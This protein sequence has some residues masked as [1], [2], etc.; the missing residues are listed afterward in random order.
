MSVYVPFDDQRKQD[1]SFTIKS[2]GI[3][4]GIN[5]GTAIVVMIGFSLL[6]PRNSLVYA[7]KAKF[8]TDKNRPPSIAPTGWL[9]WIKPVFRVKDEI[10]LQQIGC[11]AVLYIRFVRLLRKLLLC[12]SVIGLGALIP[13]YIIATKE[14]GDWPPAAGSIEILSISGINSQN[15]KLVETPNTVWYWA[16]FSATWGFSILIA[17]F[18][19]RASCDY[20][21]MRQY[22]FR[23]PS[24]EATMKSLMVS[25]IPKS[26]QTDQDLK[27]WIESTR[28]IQHPI[29]DSMMGHHSNKLSE[30]YENHE[31]AVHQLET[32]LASYLSDGKNTDSKK[33]PTVRVG[34]MFFGLFGGKK[35]DAIE[36][37][38][39]QVAELDGEIKKLRKDQTKTAPYGWISFDKI[40]YAHQTERSLE[41]W[42]KKTDNEDVFQV[43]LSPTPTNLIWNNLPMNEKARKSKRWIGRI[44]YWVFVFVWM[45][46]MT[47]LSAT[48]NVINL[49]RLIPNSASFIESHQVLMGLIQAY[50]TPIVMAIF[51]YLLPIFFRFLSK[52]QGYWTQT[53]LDRKVLTKLYVFF[54]INNLLVFT[55]TSM[56]IGIYGQ[57]R[58]LIESGSLPSD[59]SISG[60][61]MQ[62]ARN[63][64][65]VSTFW[66]NFVC[67]KSLGLTMDLA[68]L[69]PLITITVKK[70]LTRPSPRE[71]REMAKPPE[72]NFPQNY[73]LL[74]FFFTIA[75]VY[76]A[77]SPLILPFALIYFTVAGM[78]YK[79]MLMYVYVTKI[80]SGG[81]IWPVLFQTIMTSVIFFQVTMIIMLVLKGGNLQAYILI[82]LP[83]MTLAFQYFYYRRMHTL[84][85]YLIGSDSN[86]PSNYI[87]ES[88]LGDDHHASGKKKPAA[89]K[90][91]LRDQFQDPAYHD[92]LSTPTVHEDVKHLLQK[93][94]RNSTPPAATSHGNSQ[95]R[96]KVNETIEMVQNY[97]KNM[98]HDMDL[99]QQKGFSHKHHIYDAGCPIQFETVTE[100]D[101]LEAE[102][103]D[104]EEEVTQ[105]Q[106]EMAHYA[107]DDEEDMSL[108][109]SST[110]ASSHYAASSYYNNNSDTTPLLQQQPSAPPP[111][112]THT[113]SE[114]FLTAPQT[115]MPSTNNRNITSEYIEMYSSFTPNAS[116]V[117]IANRSDLRAVS[118]EEF[119]TNDPVEPP[120]AIDRKRHTMPYSTEHEDTDRHLS[121][122]NMYHPSL[123][124]MDYLS[125]EDEDDEDIE[126]AVSGKA[127][128]LKRQLSAPVVRRRHENINTDLKRHNTV[129][130]K[131]RQVIN[132][133]GDEYTES[134]VEYEE[135]ILVED[136][137]EQEIERPVNYHRIVTEESFVDN[138][139]HPTNQRNNNV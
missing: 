2:M 64:S 32:A 135:K 131:S 11:D 89:S 55:L 105:G 20:I 7:P 115:R 126:H 129:P 91:S 36:H 50:F 37:Y 88:F 138:K 61:V 139:R 108:T 28:A 128:E 109:K 35:V 106:R 51:F 13:V 136:E 10:L 60:Y 90:S 133:F 70:F 54:I 43:R 75:L 103:E 124:S 40:E 34:G 39:K 9:S 26:K 46:P 116:G 23:L 79:Y 45:I 1:A 15:G 118:L 72:F 18:M 56:L 92:K 73:N 111:L 100:E 122:P 41:K 17:Y 69:V 66:I 3:Q 98:A 68:M 99:D 83:F 94:Y 137:D 8:S 101:I 82:P 62:I 119:G 110:F 22:Y 132:P 52:Q 48:S 67:L 25:H 76:S 49:I 16:P 59:T 6:R 74:L 78:V 47:A 87:D 77:M 21:D 84:G 53:T 81:K 5:L 104:D 86:L 113:S 117:N 85:S 97:S 93:V 57:I 29:K 33:R 95:H 30:I 31:I 114:R 127:V 24:N 38:T 96:H 63:I 121:L 19:Y 58:A 134:P 14:T 120:L 71:L 112:P 102:S 80:E 123:A 4:L 125:E 42:L 130:S 44:I 12:M 27:V 107:K 65:E